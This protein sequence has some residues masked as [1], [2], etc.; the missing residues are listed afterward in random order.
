VAEQLV[1]KD[2]VYIL[3]KGACISIAREGALKLK[4][5]TYIHAEAICAGEMKHGPI[6]MIDSDKPK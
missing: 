5:T 4:E 1:T 2:S 3:A 6:A